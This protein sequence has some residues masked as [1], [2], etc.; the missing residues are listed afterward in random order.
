[1]NNKDCVYRHQYYKCSNPEKPE[2]PEDYDICFLTNKLI[3]SKKN[4]RKNCV[5]YRSRFGGNINE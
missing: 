5:Y 3:P 2:S 4:C 1:M